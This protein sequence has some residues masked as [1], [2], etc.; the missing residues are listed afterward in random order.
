VK[1]IHSFLPSYNRW[2]NSMEHDK[3][4]DWS[5]Y[6]A[7]IRRVDQVIALMDLFWPE[8]MI[9]ENM[10]LRSSVMP[11]EIT[12]RE[13]YIT[14]FRELGWS[15]SDIEF[16]VNHVHIHD[17]FINDPDYSIIPGEV[18][19]FLAYAI[20]EMWACKLKRDFPE[21][22]VEVGV[23]MDNGS[24]EVYIVTTRNELET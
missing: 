1:G 2:I 18:Y 23:K 14:Q 4:A 9:W 22:Q 11:E 6:I 8:F 16:V 7:Y 13:E 5:L 3:D 12:Q 17:E 24:P 19:E 10:L 15:D 20:S 21:R